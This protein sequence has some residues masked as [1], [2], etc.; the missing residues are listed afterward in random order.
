MLLI[1]DYDGFSNIRYVSLDFVW[2]WVE[3]QELPAALTTVATAGLIGKTIESVLQVRVSLTLSLNDSVRLD[4]RT[5]VPHVVGF[6]V[7]FRYDRLLGRCR[8]CAMINHGGLPCSREQEPVQANPP[9]KATRA[10]VT[11]VTVFSGNASSSL[12]IPKPI[13]PIVPKEKRSISIRDVLAFPSPT[14]ITGARRGRE[15]DDYPDG[16]R[17]CS[18]YDSCYTEPK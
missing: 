13:F 3:I 9:E 6:T 14:K 4:R 11:F 12:S 1:N 7:K 10:A 18:G 16:K 17:P 5:K 15:E 8:T 2:I